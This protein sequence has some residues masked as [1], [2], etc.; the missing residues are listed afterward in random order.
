MTDTSINE[1]LVGI[2]IAQAL[3]V[4]AHLV[5]ALGENAST[6]QVRQA[7]KVTPLL[8]ASCRLHGLPVSMMSDARTRLTEIEQSAAIRIEI[9]YAGGRPDKV[10]RGLQLL[11]ERLR[12]YR[13]HLLNTYDA[14]DVERIDVDSFDSGL[15]VHLSDQIQ[16]LAGRIRITCS[17]CESSRGWTLRVIP[18]GPH[19]DTE[20]V[21][22]ECDHQQPWHPMMHPSAVTGIWRW[23]S[24]GQGEQPLAVQQAQLH[25]RTETAETVEWV[26]WPQVPETYWLETWPAE[27]AAQREWLLG[28]PT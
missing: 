9:G 8:A 16:W 15:T 23:V 11:A 28:N 21:C 4:R 1:E 25:R 17:S 10:D 20:V 26:A 27:F 5:D 3:A 19:F 7:I 12:E 2:E 13:D 6:G 18:S 14:S 24:T 22:R